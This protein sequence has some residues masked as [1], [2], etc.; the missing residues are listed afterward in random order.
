MSWNESM[1]K[2]W[3]QEEASE[4]IKANGAKTRA[5]INREADWDDA[6]LVIKEHLEIGEKVKIKKA[7]WEVI[8]MEGLGMFYSP[9]TKGFRVYILKPLAKFK[10]GDTVRLIR[11]KDKYLILGIEE[12]GLWYQAKTNEGKKIY[13]SM[14]FQ[15]YITK[16]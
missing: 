8:D 3:Y 5:A 12:S 14:F 10:V 15:D 9:Q 13:L 11:K 1:A 2:E 7:F 16:V 4:L 6:H